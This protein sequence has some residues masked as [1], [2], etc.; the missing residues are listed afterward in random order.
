MKRVF[1]WL[2][3][4]TGLRTLAHQVLYANIP[5]G[6]RW[7]FVWG[8]LVGFC[9]LIQFITGI[10]L[11]LGYSP[12]VQSAWE[13]VNYLQNEVSGGWLLRG[14]HH[15]TAQILP[16]ML[17]LHLMQVVIDGAYK[18]PREVN[19]WVGLLLLQVVLFMALTGYQ[20]P[21]D[22]KGFWATKVAMNILGI[23]P[24]V[25]HSLQTIL[26]GGPDYG[27][28]T[29]TRFFGIHAGVLPVTLLAVIVLYFWLFR[30]HGFAGLPESG[31]A[32]APFWPD[33]A[34]KNAV[35]CLVVMATLLV[36]ILRHKIFHTPG[37]LGAEL[38]APA[39]PS[40]PY[41]AARPEWYFLFLYQFLKYFPGRFE[42]V[43]A[44]IVPGLVMGF[45]FM[46]PLTGKNQFW[47]RFNAGALGCLF[48]GVGLLTYLALSGDA[49]NMD[50]QIA[51]REAG[52]QAERVTALTHSPMGVPPA[53]ALTLLRNDP[54]TQGPALF[55]KNCASCH[56]FKGGDG[57]GHL[58]KDPQS[59][60]D[61]AGFGSREWL[62]GLLDPGRIGTTNYF[63]ETTH[64]NGKMA[65][66]VK[67]DVANYTPEQKAQLT[68]VIAAL[69]GEANLK[70]QADLDQRDAAI[71]ADGRKL[72][73]E[74]MKCT[75]CHQFGRHD[76]DASAPDLTGYASREWLVKFLNNP[77]HPDFYGKNNDRMPAYGEKEILSPQAIGLI[78]DWL[79]HDWYEE[80]AP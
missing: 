25:G 66:F 10:C 65:K 59:A 35:A 20:L 28:L 24:V 46:M 64:A 67:K 4:R 75:D 45:I 8:S 26:I 27:Q 49:R 80:S 5:G 30:R 37:P 43:G 9:L 77:A 22:Q 32:D 12:S 57:A 53:G 6:A 60:S 51:V 68:K 42:I 21:W 55:A 39:D 15:Y 13:S 3:E 16:V 47:R 56:R 69:S 34:L 40:E 14:L 29:L 79:R 17:A 31:R 44:L 74:E 33:Q 54:L 11:W 41:S 73:R 7:R 62:T 71:I 38:T 18:A 23:V 58:P 36:L 1:D 63:G 19:F 72:L 76:D 52:R 78:A 50:Y 70:L 2:D 48:C 61:L